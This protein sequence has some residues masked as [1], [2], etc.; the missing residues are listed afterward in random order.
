MPLTHSAG[1]KFGERWIGAWNS[2][3]LEIIMSLYDEQIV[4]QSPFIIKLANVYPDLTIRGKENLLDYFK[5]GLEKYP[6]LQFNLER[7]QVGISSIVVS[8]TSL[9]EGV[10]YHSAEFMDLN[11]A[12]DKCIACKCHYEPSL[13]PSSSGINAEYGGSL[14]IDT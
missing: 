14:I 9:K 6:Y 13:L 11:E 7:V 3:D 12:G 1:K 2:H 4:F 8:Y 10:L 5:K